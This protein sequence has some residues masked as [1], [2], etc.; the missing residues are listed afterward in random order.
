MNSVNHEQIIAFT[1][2]TLPIE[3]L[4]YSNP[5]YFKKMFVKFAMQVWYVRKF[6]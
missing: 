2:D 1:L 5:W 6:I 3:T 4:K